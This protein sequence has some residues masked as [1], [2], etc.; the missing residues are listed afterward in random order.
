MLWLLHHKDL[1]NSSPHKIFLDSL[2]NR[3]IQPLTFTNAEWGKLAVDYNSLRVNKIVN[4]DR[5]IIAHTRA[6]LF[7]S[8][9]EHGAD[10][11]VALIENTDFEDYVWAYVAIKDVLRYTPEG[12]SIFP[13]MK[14]GHSQLAVSNF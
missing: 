4:T 13:A 1:G 10:R 3:Y 8:L 9:K 5:D 7:N 6:K 12:A 2:P 14:F 11:Y